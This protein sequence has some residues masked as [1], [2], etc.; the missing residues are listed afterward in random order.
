MPGRV[1]RVLPMVFVL[2]LSTP[3]YAY[4]DPGTGSILLQALM[5]I[6]AVVFI[7]VKTYWARIKVFLLKAMAKADKTRP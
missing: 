1:F 4:I 3:A 2:L 6:A 5:G 7:T